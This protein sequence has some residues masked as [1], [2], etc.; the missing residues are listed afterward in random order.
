MYPLVDGGTDIM[1]AQNA[2]LPIEKILPDSTRVFYPFEKVIFENVGG[3]KARLYSTYGISIE[4]QSKMEFRSLRGNEFFRDTLNGSVKNKMNNNYGAIAKGTGYKARHLSGVW[5][6][7]PYLHNG[8]VPNM[9]VLLTKDT[10]RP[11]Y[12][13]VHN[14]GTDLTRDEKLSL[15]EYLKVLP[16]ESEYSW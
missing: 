5:A 7:A 13:N 2:V 3:V 9:M 4:D 16:P 10:D 14:W 11:D 6:T 15:V 12:F 1:A 8:S